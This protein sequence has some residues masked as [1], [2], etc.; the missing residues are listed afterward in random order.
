MTIV[1]VVEAGRTRV[2]LKTNF[3]PY[4]YDHLMN[5]EVETACTCGYDRVRQNGAVWLVPIV[6]DRPMG[7][8]TTLEGSGTFPIPGTFLP[9]LDSAA[10]IAGTFGYSASLARAPPVND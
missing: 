10:N 6:P 3:T 2:T 7:R 9:M 4:D 8:T 1:D 5:V